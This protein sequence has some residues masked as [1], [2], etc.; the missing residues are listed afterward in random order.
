MINYDIAIIGGGASGLAAAI[1]AAE[2][3]PALKIVILER[4]SRVGKK[5]LATGNGRCNFTNRNISRDCYYGSCNKIYSIIDDINIE[6]FF[7]RLG[8]YGYADEEGRVYPLSNSAS[9]ILDGLRLKISQFTNIDTIC[10]FNVTSI[11]KEKVFRI[12]SENNY[13]SARR[14][15]VAGGGMSQASLGSDGSVLRILKNMGLKVSA[16]SPALTSFKVNPETVRSLKGIRA[17]AKVSLYSDKEMLGE[18]E[19]EIQFSD[20]VISGICVFNLSCLCDNH[21]NLH[22]SVDFLPHIN[23][24]EL[25]DILRSIQSTRKD[26]AIEDFLTGLLHKR[27]GMY[28]LKSVTD[29]ALTE[30]VSCLSEAELKEI[31]SKIK[32]SAYIING[33]SGFEKSQVTAGGVVISEITDKLC[34]KKISGLYLCGELLDITGKCG[35]YN[36]AFAFASG[37]LAGKSCAE[38]LK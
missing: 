5:I 10:D 21:K 1:S 2:L 14:I 17:S 35:G 6:D 9:S 13:V 19:G 38:D 15:I 31:A 26:A 20:G 28:I 11:K 22:L 24:T 7:R 32:N 18:E 4:L 12:S 34:S 33:L 37:I 23:F 30:K 29:K 16:L 25:T 3:N 36:L 8:V 27:I